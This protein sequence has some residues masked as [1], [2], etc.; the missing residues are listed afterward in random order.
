MDHCHYTSEVLRLAHGECN[1]E[2]RTPKHIPVIAHNSQNYDL[3][4][5]RE[6]CQRIDPSSIR[7][8]LK[9]ME[10]YISIKKYHDR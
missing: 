5:I 3:H 1:R 4:L 9:T 2:R 6:L 7:L 8:I 10:M